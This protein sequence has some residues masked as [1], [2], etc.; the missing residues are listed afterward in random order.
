M[1]DLGEDPMTF[2]RLSRDTVCSMSVTSQH[3]R[4][5]MMIVV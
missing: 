5:I 1:I 2:Y 3:A 4:V